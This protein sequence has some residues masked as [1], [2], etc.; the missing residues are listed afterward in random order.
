MSKRDLSEDE[1]PLIKAIALKE[2]KLDEEYAIHEKQE[3]EFIEP[4]LAQ[5][6]KEMD[7]SQETIEKLID[8]Y[9]QELIDLNDTVE[10]IELDVDLSMK[11]NRGPEHIVSVFDAA[12]SRVEKVIEG[13]QF[14]LMSVYD[15]RREAIKAFQQRVVDAW[16][17]RHPKLP[18]HLINP[19]YSL[20][21]KEP[22]VMQISVC[23]AAPKTK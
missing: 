5:M 8:Q 10:E 3:K 1:D 4:L 11:D 7:V 19:A 14:R 18:A 16:N 6:R 13:T 23:R 21:G 12:Y 20:K 9:E 15:E 2:A 22:H 17:K